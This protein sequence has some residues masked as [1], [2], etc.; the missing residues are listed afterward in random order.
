MAKY[1]KFYVALI[2]VILLGGKEFFGIAFGVTPDQIFN[3]LVMM[4]TAFGV[5]QVPNEA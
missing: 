3:I 4:A 5:Y 2:G 1:A